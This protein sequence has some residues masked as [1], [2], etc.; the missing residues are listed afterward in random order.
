[1]NPIG[2]LDDEIGSVPVA[3]TLED[4]MYPKA[5]NQVEESDG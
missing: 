3:L 2:Q 4:V 1:V 5:Q